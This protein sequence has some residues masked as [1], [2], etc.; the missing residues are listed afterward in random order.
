MKSLSWQ[1]QA[2]KRPGMW[3]GS[4][5]NAGV[6]HLINEAIDNAVDEYLAGYGDTISISITN[7][8]DHTQT[9]TISDRGRGIP[10]GVNEQ[11]VNTFT[12]SATVMFTGGKYDNNSY[13]FNAGMN[14]SGL[15]LINVFSTSLQLASQR[16][17]HSYTQSFSLGYPVSDVSVSESSLTGTTVTFT[18]DPAIF[19]DY[20]VTEDDISFRCR[21]IASLIKGCRVVSTIDGNPVCDFQYDTELDTLLSD[22]IPDQQPLFSLDYSGSLSS[23]PDA[24]G[25]I[26]YRLSFKLRYF[27]TNDKSS[28]SF[29]N[30]VH[31]SDLG[32]HD[33]SFLRVIR[34]SL[35]RITGYSLNNSQISLG[36]HYVLSVSKQNPVFRGQSKTRVSDDVIYNVIQTDLYPIIYQ[37]FSQN[38]SFIRYFTQLI[39]SQNKLIEE[40]ALKEATQSIKDSV[41]NNELPASLKIAY[42]YKPEIREL[43]LVEGKSASGTVKEASLPYQE[44]LP[45]RGKVLNT[46]KADFSAIMRNKEVSDIFK[47]VGG[48]ENTNTQLRTHNVY[49]LVDADADGKS[50]YSC[51]ITLFV[52]LFPS[53]IKKHNLYV[54]HAPLFTATDGVHFEYANTAKSASAKFRKRW[55]KSSFQ[56]LRSKGLGEMDSISLVPVLSPET[57]V[58][59]KVTLTEDTESQIETIMGKSIEFR[60]EFLSDIEGYDVTSDDIEFDF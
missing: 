53:F 4:T 19:G 35:K 27:P 13:R 24:T 52:K 15:K 2:R 46:A 18:P 58:V 26:P 40:T 5:G 23:F 25:E 6:L 60:K 43:F 20:S 59:T 9:F 11:G 14:G 57:R 33:D 38:T 47:A 41:R 21:C 37:A 45:L 54:C 50:I 31:T 36:L 49:I 12:A 28:L 55:K 10:Y 8:P 39:T 30:T 3:I 32:S 48:M 7:N 1:E 22:I 17:N 44:V 29:C 34:D 16:D 51:I 42:G 56:V